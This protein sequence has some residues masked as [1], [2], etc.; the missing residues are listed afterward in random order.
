MFVKVQNLVAG[1]F[2]LAPAGQAWNGSKQ[3]N[4]KNP[5][6][7]IN[8]PEHVLQ[9]GEIVEVEYTDQIRDQIARGY[10]KIVR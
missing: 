10:L 8:V 3:D 6:K 4:I 5:P 9:R 1:G 2:R 7:M